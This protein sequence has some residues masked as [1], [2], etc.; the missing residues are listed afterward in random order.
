MCDFNGAGPGCWLVTI[1]RKFVAMKLTVCG[2]TLLA[3]YHI[4]DTRCI[5]NEGH[6]GH[7][8]CL[9]G[10]NE[11]GRLLSLSRHIFMETK[12]F[13]CFASVSVLCSFVLESSCLLILFIL[14]IV[15]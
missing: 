12:N 5:F 6:L 1:K 3:F 9:S 10:I 7:I 15:P 11:E 14:Y 13:V 4:F 2:F 8:Y